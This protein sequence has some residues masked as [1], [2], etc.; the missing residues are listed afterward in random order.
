MHRKI[1]PPGTAVALTGPEFN[2]IVST[3]SKLLVMYKSPG[4]DHNL[5]VPARLPEFGD[6]RVLAP[7]FITSVVVKRQGSF[8]QVYPPP[9]IVGRFLAWLTENIDEYENCWQHGAFFKYT[10]EKRCYKVFLY[11]SDFE[12]LHED[13]SRCVFAGLTLGAQAEPSVADKVLGGLKASLENMVADSAYGYPGLAPMMYF[14]RD[15]QEIRSTQLEDLRRLLDNTGTRLLELAKKVGE[16]SHQLW[17]QDLLAAS[18]EGSKYPRLVII[19]PETEAG[20]DDNH[21]PI[22]RE[23][24]DRWKKAW[25]SLGLSDIGMHH[26]F[27]LHFLCE[28]D[29]SEVPCGPDGR[30]FPIAQPKDWVKRFVPLMQ[31]NYDAGST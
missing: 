3:M 20:R 11:E 12:E 8:G 27:R 5:V 9:G 16:F 19:R 22:Q 13:G 1:N 18:K 26:K 7:E 17:N 2:S 24:W 6:Q 29:L 14:S 23:G 30:G 10:H 4:A 25:E 28:H 31:V 21:E 15:I